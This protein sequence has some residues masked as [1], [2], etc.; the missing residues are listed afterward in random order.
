[1]K[2]S[3]HGTFI[4]EYNKSEL[5]V[6]IDRLLEWIACLSE[7]VIVGENFHVHGFSTNDNCEEIMHTFAFEKQLIDGEEQ[8]VYYNT[9]IKKV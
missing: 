3:N 5:D 4:D 1:M 2:F 6:D 8:I 7:N 9:S